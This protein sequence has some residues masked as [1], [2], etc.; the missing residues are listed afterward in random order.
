MGPR[1]DLDTEGGVKSSQ[2]CDH[3]ALRAVI[4]DALA[5]PQPGWSGTLF[6]GQE[7]GAATLGIVAVSLGLD[8]AV[9]L[10]HDLVRQREHGVAPFL[11]RLGLTSAE[12]RVAVRIGRGESPS[13]AAQALGVTQDTVR[14]QIR[15][16]FDT[17]GFKWQSQV[18]VL[19]TRL[20]ACLPPLGDDVDPEAIANLLDSGPPP[21]PFPALS[22]RR[23][24]SPALAVGS[25]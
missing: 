25:P 16:I 20:E 18:A 5:E 15:A 2:R 17:L 21:I 7:G 12:A 8:G 6:V 24:G 4:S 11:I 10:L 9:L 1:I 3:E 22:R 19:V 14:S 23:I 13:A